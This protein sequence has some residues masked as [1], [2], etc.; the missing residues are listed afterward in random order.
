MRAHSLSPSKCFPR[1]AAQT[2]T[3]VVCEGNGG[4]EAKAGTPVWFGA[5]AAGILRLTN[6]IES[7]AAVCLC[8]ESLLDTSLQ[9]STVFSFF[10]Q[11]IGKPFQPLSRQETFWRNKCLGLVGTVDISGPQTLDSST[12]GPKHN[13]AQSLT[14][15]LDY[16][17]ISL[18]FFFPAFLPFLCIYT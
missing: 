3:R 1:E 11:M 12:A 16:L 10:K 13:Q 17:K 15:I 9:Y 5:G 14:S 8:D 4:S 2:S 18:V 6:P 7:L